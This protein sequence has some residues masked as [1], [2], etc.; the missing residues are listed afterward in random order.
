MPNSAQHAPHTALAVIEQ[1]LARWRERWR[2]RH[3]LDNFDRQELERMAGEFGMTGHDLEGLVARGPQA[4][5]LLYERMRA[6]GVARADVERTAHGLMRDLER[7]CACCTEKGVCEGDL[8]IRPGDP[9]WKAYCPN[10]VPL[11]AMQKTKGRFPA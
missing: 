10:A 6:L 3:E 1:W 4:A 8:A 7:T 2:S 9:A 11:E 5:D